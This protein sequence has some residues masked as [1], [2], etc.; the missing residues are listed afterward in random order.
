[1]Q[2][3]LQEV[4]ESFVA[5]TRELLQKSEALLLDMER[6]AGEHH[7]TEL[8]RGIHTIKGNAG[9][10]ELESL[11]SLCHA[12]ETSLERVRSS[13]LQ[14]TTEQIDTGLTVLDRMRTIVSFIDQPEKRAG[15]TV[16]DLVDRL[17]ARTAKHA[18]P[19]Q[20]A[21]APQ[22]S[23][24]DRLREK[25]QKLKLPEKYLEIARK[26]NRNLIFMV[27][28]FGDQGDMTLN[29]FYAKMQTL[30]KSQTLL[31]LGILRTETG[32]SETGKLFLP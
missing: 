30:H 31:S 1:M 8:L 17:E 18:E 32:V 15:V 10:F 2:I 23:N 13:G 7:Y 3:N 21:A 9:I 27:I 11:I 28:D 12:F 29:A 14:L 22:K 6:Q 26:G 24:F 5:T 20:P 16:Q 4:K 19:V 25:T